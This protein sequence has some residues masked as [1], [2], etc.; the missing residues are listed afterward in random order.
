MPPLKQSLLP[1]FYSTNLTSSPTRPPILR[2][3]FARLEALPRQRARERILRRSLGSSSVAL[4]RGLFPITKV[5]DSHIYKS[6]DH[7]KEAIET[8][9][10]VPII[11][12]VVASKGHDKYMLPWLPVSILGTLCVIFLLVDLSYFL[13]LGVCICV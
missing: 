11:L 6:I 9:P 1:Q 2:R 5:S 10:W 7:R 3:I 8:I 12:S 4:Q 13:F